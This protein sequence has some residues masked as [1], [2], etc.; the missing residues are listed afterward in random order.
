MSQ[1]PHVEPHFRLPAAASPTPATATP[2][3]P[4]SSEFM[5]GTWRVS[6][7]TLPM[8]KSNRNVT[9]TYTPH[10]SI[11]GA[12]DNLVKYQ[13]LSSE[14]WKTVK[15]IETPDPSIPAA[16]NWRGKGWLMIAS[17][18]WEVL[19]YGESEGGWCVI[20]FEKTLFTPAG[21]DILCRRRE[22]VSDKTLS[23]VQTELHKLNNQGL[24]LLAK[25]LFR[26]KE[27]VLLFPS[28]RALE[29]KISKFHLKNLWMIRMRV[30]NQEC[31]AISKGHCEIDII[32]SG[33]SEVSK[34]DVVVF[35][36]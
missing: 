31:A 1:G 11:S 32:S 3:V 35:P 24:G 6:F 10:Q 5:T 25:E 16:W 19:G 14:K 27:D 23:I 7:S 26:V 29:L 9:I 22:G 33:A 15:G 20:W 30:D 12:W 4:P 17:S 18:H 36:L 8:W 34:T 13:P 21:M 2:F 28:A